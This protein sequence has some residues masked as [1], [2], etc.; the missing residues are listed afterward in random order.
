MKT[1]SNERICVRVS[2]LAT[3]ITVVSSEREAEVRCAVHAHHNV[4]NWH[5]YWCSLSQGHPQ[6]LTGLFGKILERC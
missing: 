3:G 6:F 2:D 4:R 5:Q 1:D